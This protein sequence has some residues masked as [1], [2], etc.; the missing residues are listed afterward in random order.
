MNQ[1]MRCSQ[2]K[3]RHIDFSDTIVYER[4]TSHKLRM[5]QI[6]EEVKLDKDGNPYNNAC[7]VT[8]TMESKLRRKINKIIRDCLNTLKRKEGN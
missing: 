8:I 7:P 1:K 4:E 6:M 3:Q 5:K 2:C